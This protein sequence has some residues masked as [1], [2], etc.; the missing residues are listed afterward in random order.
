MTNNNIHTPLE[1]D[2]DWGC[3]QIGP[4]KKNG[5]IPKVFSQNLL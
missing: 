4:K 1:N 2:Y 3:I 5:A